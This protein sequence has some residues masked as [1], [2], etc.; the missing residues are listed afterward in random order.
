[1]AIKVLGTFVVENNFQLRA[2]G[3]Y[4]Q[5][6]YDRMVAAVKTENH[7]FTIYNSAGTAIKTVSLV[8]T[9]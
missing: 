2:I 4:D 5:S 9:A 6:V 7:T 8:N 1:M 3:G